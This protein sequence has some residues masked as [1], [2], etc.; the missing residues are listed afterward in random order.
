MLEQGAKERGKG[1]SSIPI[2]IQ[3]QI[4]DELNVK[5]IAIELF[6]SIEDLKA[7][8]AADPDKWTMSASGDL[9]VS[10]DTNITPEL[11]NEGTAREI[12][13][14]IQSMRKEA[15]FELTDRIFICYQCSDDLR[16][17]IKE[18]ADYINY[19]TLSDGLTQGIPIG[20]YIEGCMVN[21]KEEITL[22]IGRK[23]VS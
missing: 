20:G 5:A 17:V 10:L 1:I 8:V 3:Q 16:R 2:E 22:L 6:D 21:K 4:L 18:Y 7:M 12:V 9:A 13:H 23:E 19:E 14:R 15:G 11:A